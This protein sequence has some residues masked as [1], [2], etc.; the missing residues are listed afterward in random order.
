MTCPECLFEL[1][2]SDLICPRCEF[3]VLRICTICGSIYPRTEDYFV[4]KIIRNTKYW[5]S[6]RSCYS[7]IILERLRNIKNSRKE[8]TKKW[9]ELN[10]EKV[11]QYNKNYYMLNRDKL[12][13]R[14]REYYKKYKIMK[15]LGLSSVR[16]LELKDNID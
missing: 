5:G 13:P 4:T 1:G 10:K 3:K 11:Q 15:D 7:H 14:A 8:R 16:E 6:C 9:Q 12:L 2:P